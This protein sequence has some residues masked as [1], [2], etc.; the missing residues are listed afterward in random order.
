V[1]NILIGQLPADVTEELIRE[2][3]SG[4]VKVKDVTV[5]REGSPEKVT[6]VVGV[7]ESRPAAE[8]VV[9]RI[10]GLY[11]RGRRLRAQLSGIPD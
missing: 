6:A 5:V 4:V 10:N 2:R 1:L 9:R 7:D 8:F 3:L 11:F